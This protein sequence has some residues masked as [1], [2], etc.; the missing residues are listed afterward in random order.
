MFRTVSTGQS[1]DRRSKAP[2]AAGG[3]AKVVEIESG[4]ISELLNDS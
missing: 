3:V 4:V 1:V 2:T